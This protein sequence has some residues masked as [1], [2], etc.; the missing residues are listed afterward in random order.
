MKDC[1]EYKTLKDIAT[2][3]TD[4]DWIESRHQS[5]DGIRLIQTGNVGD[6]FF[7]AKD[8]KPHYISEST[9]AELGCTEI[10]EGDCLVSRLPEPVGRACIIPDTG[11]RMITAVD[12]SIIRFK[13]IILPSLFIYYTRSKRYQQ[14]I[15]NS[16]TGT[17]RKRIS[18]KNLESI[19][20][21]VP[22]LPEQER[23]VAELD[24]LSG[25]IDKQK[26]QLGELDILAQSIFYDMFG[27]PVENERGWNIKKLSDIAEGKLSYGSGSTSIPFDGNIRYIRITD[28]DDNGCLKDEVVSPNDFNSKYLLN[29]GDILFARSGATVG[30]TYRHRS[31][32]GKCIYAGYLIRLIPKLEIVNPE[33]VFGFTKTHYY[34]SF[35]ALSQKAV[36]QPNINAEQYGNLSICV[37]PLSLQESFAQ[38]IQSIESQKE[39]INRSIAETQKLFNYTM[40]KYFG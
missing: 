7:K 18:R 1:W 17:T 13:D 6:G 29:D 33:Y 36:A 5:E 14:E 30:K 23:I 24:L 3:I 8:D 39:S 34:K 35:I 11:S 16:T 2:L 20:I 37:P 15:Y 10:F 19:Q 12:C 27:D 32:N 22:P 25:I 21:P 4:G 38:R 31:S 28:I 40:D 26:A 9:F